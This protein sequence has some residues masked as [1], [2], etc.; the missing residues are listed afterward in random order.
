MT[1]L[2]MPAGAEASG[3]GGAPSEPPPA[4]GGGAGRTAAAGGSR[5]TGPAT[6]GNPSTCEGTTCPECSND[7]DCAQRGMVGGTCVNKTCFAPP[8]QC[9][10]DKECESRGKEFVGGRCAAA[11]CLPNPKWRCEPLPMWPSATKTVELIVPIIDAL[12]RNGLKD[13]KVVACN[14]LDLTCAAPITMGMT[15]ADGKTKLSVPDNFTGYIQVTDLR[16]YAPSMYFLPVAWPEGGL[17]PTSDCCRRARSWTRSR[18]R[19]E[20][21]STRCAGT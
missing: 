4:A 2:E 10:M 13:V 21:R 19:S 20:A 5:S 15:G 17:L 14:K 11:K 8:R 7:A 18:A 16:G 6:P 9:S 3:E 1:L 12:S